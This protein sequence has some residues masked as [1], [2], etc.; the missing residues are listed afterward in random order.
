MR[1]KAT[2]SVS[3]SVVRG[4]AGRYLTGAGA[5][6]DSLPGTLADAD[7]RACRVAGWSVNKPARL[8]PLSG[9]AGLVDMAA[10][11][12]S[13]SRQREAVR[14][15]CLLFSHCCNLSFSVISQRPSPSLGL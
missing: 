7:G 1:E 14:V 6:W 2:S 11:N 15:V 10:E 12:D 13:E 8:A 3:G 9:A 5:L 4:T